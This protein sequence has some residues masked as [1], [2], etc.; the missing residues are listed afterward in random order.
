MK[1]LVN[2]LIAAAT[3][4]VSV[5]SKPTLSLAATDFLASKLKLDDHVSFA[6]VLK[7]NVSS[8]PSFADGQKTYISINMTNN[9]PLAKTLIAVHGKFTDLN[10]GKVILN[11]SS[12]KTSKVIEPHTSFLF[13][14][15][16]IPQIEAGPLGM[17]VVAD[18][19]DLEETGYKMV[20]MH[21]KI[22]VVYNDTY[23]DFQ[24]YVF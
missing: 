3:I 11:I 18:F 4:F 9:S 5:Q 13:K 20:A 17:L 7:H 19:Y 6:P 22:N 16:F 14:Y 8:A 2:I 15:R 1:F 21:E 24:R 10:T 12:V 23:Y